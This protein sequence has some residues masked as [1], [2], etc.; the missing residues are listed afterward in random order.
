MRKATLMLVLLAIVFAGSAAQA[1]SLST[2]VHFGIE[3]N[4]ILPQNE[5]TEKSINGGFRGFFRYGFNDT[6]RVEFGAGYL[7]YA[8]KDFVSTDYEADVIPIDLRLLWFPFGFERLSPYAYVGAGALHFNNIKVPR[9]FSIQFPQKGVEKTGWTGVFPAGLGVDYAVSEN[10]QIGATAGFNY[11]L[12]DDLNHYIDGSP[13]DVYFN[14]GLHLIFGGTNINKDSDGDGLLDKDEIYIYKTDPMKADTDGDGL[15]DGDEVLKYKTNP[16]VADTDGDGLKDGEEVLKYNTNPLKADTDG[17]GLKDGEEVLKHKTDPLKADTDGDKLNDFDE[18]TKH[19]T[20][21]LKVDTDGDTLSDYDEV[22]THKTNPLKADTDGDGLNDAEELNQ[23]KTNPLKADTD[24]DKLEDGKE[25]SQ[26]KTDPLKMDTDGDGLNDFDEL[27]TYK[28]NPLKADTDGGTVNDK[29][30]VDRG[31][32]PLDA[33]DDIIKMNVPMVLE[34]IVFETGS[35]KISPASETTLNKALKTLTAYQDISVEI[36]G[37]TDN[38]GSKPF[39]QK[40]SQDRAESVMN[41]LISKGVDAKRMTA[42]GFGPD[43]PLVPNDSD[44]NRQKNRRIE[45]VRTK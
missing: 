32:D 30:E 2:K 21:P 36:Q 5:F 35:A 42:R 12:S 45:F 24:G 13:K 20:N 10:I 28:T 1:Q 39:N 29:V 27:M 3:G 43:K 6:W 11:T 7:K 41:W 15:N 8:G 31:T 22:M 4:A 9:S 44:A 14:G 37:H 34:G 40:L 18:V 33:S 19:N 17:D 25:I 23:Y 26:F 16:L 38:V